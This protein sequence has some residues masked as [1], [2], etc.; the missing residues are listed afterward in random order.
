MARSRHRARGRRRRRTPRSACGTPPPS[1]RAA[2]RG[3]GHRSCAVAT[4][5]A[6]DASAPRGRRRIVLV[7]LAPV[8]LAIALPQRGLIETLRARRAEPP[9]SAL[10]VASTR[11]C[12]WRA[13][14]MAGQPLCPHPDRDKN[15]TSFFKSCKRPGMHLARRKRLGPSGP[16]ITVYE[17][18]RPTPI[19]PLLIS[20]R[21]MRERKPPGASRSVAPCSSPTSPL[22]HSH[23][24]MPQNH[25][26]RLL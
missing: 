2:P 20:D 13:V 25:S 3:S 10:R 23:E 24:L 14:W 22:S 26:R 15:A 8:S 19:A 4:V 1:R 21:R 9:A 16:A 17:I 7:A 12:R 5:R 18:R 6:H 11:A